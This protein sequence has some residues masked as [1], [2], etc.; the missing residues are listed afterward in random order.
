MD[1][2]PIFSMV[3]DTT[4]GPVPGTHVAAADYLYSPICLG[5]LLATAVHGLV[6]FIKKVYFYVPHT[7]ETATEY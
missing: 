2:G 5:A 6:R 3:I 1:N 4:A 7:M